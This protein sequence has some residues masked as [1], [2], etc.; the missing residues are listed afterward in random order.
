[1]KLDTALMQEVAS[2]CSGQNNHTAFNLLAGYLT[3]VREFNKG[4]EE[5][6]AVAQ[7]AEMRLRIFLAKLRQE[8]GYKH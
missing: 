3:A 8:S 6:L 4:D 1:M 2:R 7:E 5:F